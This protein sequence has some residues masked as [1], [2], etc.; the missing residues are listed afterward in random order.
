M[1]QDNWS[2]LGVRDPL[3]AASH[4]TAFILSILGTLFLWR[5]CRG[6]WRKRL[7]LACFGLSMMVLYA[8]S[9]TYHTLQLPPRQL[10]FFRLLDHSAIF[11]LIA[12]TYTPALVLLLSSRVR[13]GLLLGSIWAL[14]IG[15][16]VCKWV[17]PWEPEWLTISLYWTLGWLALLPLAELTRAAGVRAV[18]WLVYGGVSYTLAGVTD[19]IN[20]PVFFPGVF[21]SHELSHLFDMGGTFCHFLFMVRYVAPFPG[22]ARA[23]SAAANL[24]PQHETS[25]AC[26]SAN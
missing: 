25:L 17:L 18:L 3:C 19:L 16:V 20:W 1:V 12:G 22:H 7:A 15:G 9:T 2:F 8:T 14:A 13:K 23:N 10:D 11:G 26:A 21:G 6:E 4:F 24:E 5:L